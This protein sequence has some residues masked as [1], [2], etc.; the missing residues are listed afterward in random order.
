[1]KMLLTKYANTAQ[2]IIIVPLT[3]SPL[4]LLL[5]V[6]LGVYIVNLCA[7][8]FYRL[9]GKLTAFLQLQEFSLRKQTPVTSSTSA[10]RLSLPSLKS[11]VD[12]ALAKVAALCVSLNLDGAPIASKSHTHPSH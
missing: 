2:T 4:Y 3:L 11:K 6:H 12:L 8:Y 9:I 10:A 1:M 7:F 5:L